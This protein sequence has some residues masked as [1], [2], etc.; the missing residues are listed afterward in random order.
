MSPGR[1]PPRRP[2]RPRATL[3]ALACYC[4]LLAVKVL[5]QLPLHVV[6]AENLSSCVS[7]LD[8][9]FP[10]R[11]GSPLRKAVSAASSTLAGQFPPEL[12][13]TPFTAFVTVDGKFLGNDSNPVERKIFDQFSK[14]LPKEKQAS[15]LLYNLLPEAAAAL[16]LGRRGRASTQLSLVTG[17]ADYDLKFSVP[18]NFTLGGKV[19]V[20]DRLGQRVSILSSFEVC[21]GWVH[22]VDGVLW[23]ATQPVAS[24][25]PD[26]V[27]GGVAPLGRAAAPGLAPVAFSADAV[28]LPPSL[29][30]SSTDPNPN[31]IASTAFAATG[32]AISAAVN[33][34][35]SSISG[36]NG[37]GGGG[38]G[39]GP[40]PPPPRP[41]LPTSGNSSSGSGGGASADPAADRSSVI[42]G[43]VAGGAA[44]L[45]A[46]GAAAAAFGLY[47]RRRR[48]GGSRSGSRNGADDGSGDDDSD[49]DDDD[50]DDDEDD[51]FDD[52]DDIERGSAAP[53]NGSDDAKGGG[54]GDS[55][56][57]GGG[58]GVG[59]GGGKQGGGGGKPRGGGLLARLLAGLG[60]GAVARRAHRRRQRR[61]RRRRARRAAR[62]AAAAAAVEAASKVEGGADGALFAEADST[63]DGD[64][65][66]RDGVNNAIGGAAPPRLYAVWPPPPGAPRPGW[67]MR[68]E[69]VEICLDAA[70]N[71]WQLGCGGFG[72]V[73]KG[74][75]QGS[76]D[77]AVKL[78]AGHS[79]KE[80]AR[81]ANEVAILQALRHT[82]VVQFLGASLEP[83]PSTDKGSGRRS[84]AGGGGGKGGDNGNDGGSGGDNQSDSIDIDLASDS[85]DDADAEEEAASVAAS[86]ASH[87]HLPPHHPHHHN[88]RGRH[89]AR[90]ARIMLVTEYLP[91][92]DLWRALSKDAGH[93]F[94]WYRRGRAVALDVVRGLA[95]MH[96][97][98][99]MHL[100]LKSANILLGRDGTA[101]V[102]DVGLAKILTRD[103]THVSMEGT[104]D[105]AAPEV[106][107][108]QGV[109][110][111]ADIYS[112]GVV[113]W[114][115]VS[116]ERPHMRQMRPL[117]VS[118]ECPA[119]VAAV[120]SA[121][122]AVDPS[123]RPTA[124]EVYAA[125]ASA[126][127]AP[128]GVPLT[129]EMAAQVQAQQAA[130]R[131]A[132][133]RAA[134]AAAAAAARQQQPR[135]GGRSAAAGAA[136][137]AGPAA[138][139]AAA[140]P[141]APPPSPPPAAAAAAQ[142][143]DSV[144][145]LPQR[146]GGKPSPFEAQAGLP[147]PLSSA[148]NSAATSG[149]RT[150]G[151]SR[152]PTTATTPGASTSGAAAAAA[153]ALVADSSA[154][155]TAGGP[156]TPAEGS[157][158][159][160][161][162]S[163]SGGLAAR[164]RLFMMS[165]SGGGGSSADGE[166]SEK[167]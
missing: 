90:G 41:P 96:S 123:A 139:P 32:A 44:G 141:A 167:K 59:V 108:G 5:T 136:A 65:G 93:V 67:E 110:E 94:S 75:L 85:D 8:E 48:L 144:A 111:K 149:A 89:A 156:A 54:A 72:A 87:P 22:T 57:K 161:N 21:A 14:G 129:A 23:P 151:S 155:S 88:Q 153:S 98:K 62:A 114:E 143:Q 66:G 165:S 51:L 11:Q 132:A 164:A 31:A 81:F 115:I 103:A 12:G 34:I 42:V 24:A 127:I 7:K 119:E 104:F 120:V 13:V 142:A 33:T 91:R 79:P 121:C 73:Y 126:P 15:Y 99:V 159:P 116:G 137:G 76:T 146:N 100:D 18:D 102:A 157:A 92:G 26:P 122:R 150:G 97:K 135:G 130:A 50:D 58:A 154:P 128:H 71:R 82:N 38:G 3:L 68:P 125:L 60:L 9:L 162:A 140:A 133:S 134:A 118:D 83:E 145:P 101:K 30:A 19:Q 77:V 40:L 25:I 1:R 39:G 45:L 46:L 55:A 112:L 37:T 47:A 52:D 4:A 105:W 158:A 117:R 86:Q 70:G 27:K 166:A 64:G 152:P 148:V 63:L 56:G 95:F 17:L 113:L 29:N 10:A 74:R 78:V 43:G 6:A 138:P 80:L 20:V 124:R 84:A 53:I 147:L 131:A 28:S 109:S 69:D 35:Q 16:T 107:S 106:L 61:R 36:N 2:P 49:G 163:A 160:A